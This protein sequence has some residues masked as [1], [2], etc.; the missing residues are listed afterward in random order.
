M[1]TPIRTLNRSGRTFVAACAAA[2]VLAGCAGAPSSPDGAADARARLTALQSNANLANLAPVA[3]AEAE[4]A[5]RLAEEPVGRDTELGAHR[6][7]MAERKVGIAEAKASTRYAEDQR[8]RLSEERGEARLQARTLE[9]DRARAAT[10]LA[11]SDADAERMLAADAAAR[12]A[13][14]AEELQRQIE[15]LKAEA[16]ERGLVL[17]LGDLLFAFDSADL[18]AGATGTL[19]RLVGFLNQYP[20][21]NVK[22]EGHTDNVGNADYN[23]RLSQRRAESV[24]SYLVN[25]GVGFARISASGMGQDQ[26]VVGNDSE[27]GRQ[28]NR[29]VELIIDNPPATSVSSSVR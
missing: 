7:F 25:Q 20:N 19:D 24:R 28:Q 23:Y 8:T 29:R 11:R 18:R 26:P 13:Q 5:V 1:N 6:V 3:L 27:S 15:A 14:E 22:I 4:D 16:T 10:D 9:A 21:R 2:L 17:T 12:A